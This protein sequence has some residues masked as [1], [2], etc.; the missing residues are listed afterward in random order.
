MGLRPAVSVLMTVYNGG[1]FLQSGIESVLNQTLS[2]FELIAVD[3]G[4]TDQTPRV[5]SGYDDPRMRVVTLP[6][7]Q[8]I[9]SARNI[10]IGEARSDYCAFLSH[11]DV[12]LPN[13][14]EEQ[15]RF[16]EAHSDIGMVGS[17]VE[18]IDEKGEA[19]R[20]VNMPRRDLEIRWTALL[21]CPLRQ[22]AIM[23]RTELARDLKYS[24]QFLSYSDY[25]FMSRLLHVTRAANL[26]EV[27]VQYR[28]HATNISTRHKDRLIRSGMKISHAAIRAELPAYAIEMHD[29]TRLRAVFCDQDIAD[30]PK[31]L[32]EYKS[33]LNMYMDLLDAFRC[34]YQDHPDV[35]RLR[36]MEPC[37]NNPP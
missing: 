23:V 10:A 26:P 35:K 1:P 17:D 5:L 31:S 33:I 2:D 11:D 16:L 12:A 13:R 34:K 8:G 15:L 9:P 29:V 30:R 21:E 3:D 20:T 14:L 19:L 25:D 22:S 37:S 32:V 7:N 18:V 4:S 24:E 36:P 27:L 6:N 28:R